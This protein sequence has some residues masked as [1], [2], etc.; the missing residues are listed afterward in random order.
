MHFFLMN[1]IILDANFRLVLRR[2]PCLVL[3]ST[4]LKHL[5]VFAAH[6]FGFAM[7]GYNSADDDWIGVPQGSL[8]GPFSLLVLM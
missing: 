2:V 1:D 6:G 7:K 8:F 5:S 4:L 3:F